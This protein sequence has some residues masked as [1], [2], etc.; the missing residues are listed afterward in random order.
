MVQKRLAFC[1]KHLFMTEEEWEENVMFSDESMF[2]L[3]NPRAQTVRRSLTQSR[4]LQK[5]I[6][7]TMKHPVLVMIWGSFSGRGSRG[8]STSC[9]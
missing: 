9:H 5:F 7:R 2:R 4:Y 8:C 1:K 6:V 3:I